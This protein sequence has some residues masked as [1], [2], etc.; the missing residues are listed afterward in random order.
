MPDLLI[1]DMEIPKT[2]SQCPICYD[3]MMCR[4]LNF[5]FAEMESFDCCDDR[6]GGCPLIQVPERTT[7]FSPYEVCDAL[8]EAGQHDKK[9]KIGDTIKY[10][11]SEVCDILMKRRSNDAEI[12]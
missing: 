1:L 9:F 3:Y 6:L 8:V 2:C 12:H 5:P 11:P 7:G 4:L 10:S